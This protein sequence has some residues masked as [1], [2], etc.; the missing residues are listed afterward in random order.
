VT[1]TSGH[2]I[3]SRGRRL[4]RLV[5]AVGCVLLIALA[6]V[7]IAHIEAHGYRA[8]VHA[9]VTQDGTLAASGDLKPADPAGGGKAVCPPL[10][11]ALAGP[12]TGP[13]VDAGINIEHGVRLAVDN[14]NSANPGC[15]V[16]VK[17]FD[18]SSDPERSSD[19][20]RQIVADAYT[21]GVIGPTFSGVAEATGT[22]FEDNGIP[23]ATAS[24]SRS[25]L[26]EQGRETFF[27]AVASDEAQGHTVANYLKNTLQAKAVCVV[28][29]G[30]PY[31]V[32]V[33]DAAVT[34]LGG[35]APA[36]C[37]ASIAPG[38]KEIALVVARIKAASPDV[39]LR[40]GSDAGAADFARRLRD[41]GV[42][43]TFVTAQGMAGGAFLERAD[44][45]A[46]GALVICPCS[47][48]PEWFVNE[49]RS[50]FGEAPGAYSAE[51]Y[52]LATIMLKGIDAGNLVRPQMLEWMRRY[53]GQGVAR[54][55]QWTDTGEL[56]NPTVWI[57][58][59]E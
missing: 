33:A 26:S 10:S 59:V 58:K 28:D 6:A 49:Y 32:A 4:V 43:A 47:P 25:A 19:L 3:G 16:Q 17:E 42:T 53:E 18:T 52:D 20:A 23:A 50:K 27:R 2:R 7:L 34:T 48:A 11:I 46:K 36:G 57:Y 14:H 40:A 1:D 45:A 21:V 38:D 35:L 55:Y 9:Q 8:V 31:G 15:Q 54:R 24:A 41:G 5:T 51:G 12:L 37:R 56:M 29:D 44:D 13:D 22:L 30:D 39:V